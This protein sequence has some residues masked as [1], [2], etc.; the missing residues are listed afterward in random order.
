MILILLFCTHT[1]VLR[2]KVS[3]I[4]HQ[5]LVLLLVL[6]DLL[7]GKLLGLYVL[8]EGVAELLVVYVFDMFFY[9]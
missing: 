1:V 8:V 7:V 4:F 9:D 5:V 3:L 2:F 6:E